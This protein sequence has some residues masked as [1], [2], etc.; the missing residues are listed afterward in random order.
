MTNNYYQDK[1]D[2]L[3]K[4]GKLKS[5]DPKALRRYRQLASPWY[6][7]DLVEDGIS[8]C[9]LFGDRQQC[10]AARKAHYRV[11]SNIIKS[12]NIIKWIEHNQVDD[13]IM[14]DLL[15]KKSN[16]IKLKKNQD[17]RDR[18]LSLDNVRADPVC[19]FFLIPFPSLTLSS[20]SLQCIPYAKQMH[21]DHR[22]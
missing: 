5:E 9:Q 22:Q 16:I 11:R 3:I 12:S 15:R 10:R 6:L 21:A 18:T 2:D 13:L 4:N 1:L 17:S 8:I 7:G 19:G 20:V 14:F